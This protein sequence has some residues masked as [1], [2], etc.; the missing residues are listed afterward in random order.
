V[1]IQTA[2]QLVESDAVLLLEIASASK[3]TKMVRSI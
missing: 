2:F 1:E 3:L